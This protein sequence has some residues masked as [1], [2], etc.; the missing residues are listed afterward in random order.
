KG[1]VYQS[2]DTLTNPGKAYLGN[3]LFIGDARNYQTVYFGNIPEYDPAKA[4]QISFWFGNILKD[5]YLRSGLIISKYDSKGNM[6]EEDYYN[7]A[8]LARIFDGNW[9]LCELDV[10]LETPNDK[11]KVTLR[12]EEILNDDFL[13]DELIIKQVGVNLYKEVTGGIIKNNRYYL[14]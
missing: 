5:T 3:G 9:A 2:F 11:V 8:A 6:Y 14:K 12:S 13:L 1:F 4:Y 10:A 7:I